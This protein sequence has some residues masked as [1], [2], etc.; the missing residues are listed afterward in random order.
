MK[1]LAAYIRLNGGATYDLNTKKYITSGYISSKKGNELTIEG[2]IYYEMLI[3]Y[4]IEHGSDLFQPETYLGAWYDKD[5][6]ITYIDTS[7]HF[8]TLEEAVKYARE[9]DQIK[10]YHLDTKSEINIK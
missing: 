10:I 7:Y 5:T 9:N 1:K 6:N 4:I 3:D 8:S 2:L